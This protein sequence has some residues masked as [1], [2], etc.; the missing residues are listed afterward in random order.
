VVHVQYWD[1]TVIR[2]HEEENVIPFSISEE[3]GKKKFET[4]MTVFWNVTPQNAVYPEDGS[5]RY[6][7]EVY[8]DL[9][10]KS[11]AS[12]FHL[13]GTQ[14]SIPEYSNLQNHRR[15][16]LNFHNL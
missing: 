6:T 10:D 4:K 3:D 9:P 1:L 11:A 8:I 2:F 13:Q 15:Q 14:H 16:N 12:I 5:S 7:G